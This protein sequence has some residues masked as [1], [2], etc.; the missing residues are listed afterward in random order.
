MITFL[1]LFISQP[2]YVSALCP[3]SETL[4][5]LITTTANLQSSKMVVEIGSGTGV[6][7]RKI[8][9]KI[10][11]KCSFFALEI[12]PSFVNIT[13]REI[14]TATVYNDSAI[15]IDKY[16]KGTKCDA[17]ISSIPWASF[18]RK[19]QSQLL[20][21]MSDALPLEG[22]FLT[23]AYVHGSFLPSGIR[24]RKMLDSSFT[25]VKRT[26]IVWNNIPPAFVYHCI[27]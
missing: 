19:R 15:N 24:F 17:I 9:N 27:K 2:K 1:R 7:T 10:P 23:F 21:K 3:S 22:Q 5:E 16:L 8:M 12:D 14:P 4:S 18:N 13:K 11:E 25:K 6:F 26:K 20:K